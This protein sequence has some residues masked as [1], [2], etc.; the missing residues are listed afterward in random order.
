MTSVAM[1]LGHSFGVHRE[2]SKPGLSPFQTELRRRLSWQIV[3]LDIR[4][5]EDRASDPCV[6]P[7]SFN[8]IQ[9]LN[10]NDSD[11]DPQSAEPLVERKGFTDMTKVRGSHIVWNAAMRLL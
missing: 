10:I 5:C 6:L 11:M 4:G 1:R 3:A 7:D 8:T 9:P 2:G